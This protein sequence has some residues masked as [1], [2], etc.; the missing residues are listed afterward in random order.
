MKIHV[1]PGDSLVETFNKS[2]I[3]GEIIGCRECLIEGDAQAKNLI[4][5]I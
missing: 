4:A 1:L 5:E 3:E 2:D